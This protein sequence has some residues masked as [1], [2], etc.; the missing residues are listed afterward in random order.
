MIFPLE[1][2]IIS[3]ATLMCV[4]HGKGRSLYEDKGQGLQLRGGHGRSIK[5]I[6]GKCFAHACKKVKIV[7]ND[8]HR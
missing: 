1:C 8:M 4:R 2:D 6:Y 3:H 7:W 5:D